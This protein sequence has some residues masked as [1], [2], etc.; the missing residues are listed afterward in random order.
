MINRIYD[1]LNKHVDVFGFVSVNEY[2]NKRSS[3]G[4]NDVFSTIPSINEYKTI[5]TLGLSYPS[6][7]VEYKGRGYGVLSKYS[8]GTDYHIVFRNKIKA[9][10]QEL[11]NMYIKYHSSVDI[12]DLDERYAGYLSRIGYLG[13]N[14]F[15]INKEYGSYLFLATILIDINIDKEMSQLDDCGDCN[16]CVTA[17]PTNALDNGFNRDLCL[18][19]LTQEKKAFSDREIS[20]LKTMIYGCD[21]C[22]NVCPKNNGIDFHKHSEFEPTGIENINLIELLNMSNKEY[23][24]IYKNNASSWKGAL[25]IK[26]NALCLIANQ[27]IKETVP[28]IKESI[29]KFSDVSWYNET[30]KKVIKILESE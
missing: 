30:A 5:I 25:V 20:H 4:I 21:I 6:K 22:Q 7:E 15:L 2:I 23:I 26:R 11:S 14:Q 8:Y 10:E 9:I 12:S 29:T 13:K 19:S 18:S 16:I 1:I 17:C 28:I 3:M 24:D 27:K